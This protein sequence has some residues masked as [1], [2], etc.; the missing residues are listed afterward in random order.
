VTETLHTRS[1][2]AALGGLV[3]QL[4]AGG[5][6]LALGPLTHSIAVMHLAWYLLG[7]VP[8]WFVALLVFRQ[9]ELA[10]LEALDLEELRREKQATGGGEAL[11]EAEGAGGGFR[12]AEARLRWMQRWLIP[13]FGLLTALYLA[14]MGGYL[15][16]YLARTDLEI[17]G[18]NWPAPVNIA[19]GMVLLAI[20][21]LVTFVYSRYTSGMGRV[22]EWQLLRGCGAYMLGNA[23][24][25]MA[26]LVCLGVYQYAGVASW[27]HVVAYAIP[28]LM[29][30]L[31]IEAAAN[32]VLDIYRPRLAG[33]E[34]RACFD[35][36]L[37][38]LFAEPG[39]IAHSIAEA[40]NYQ[41]GFKVSQT[42]F[43][44]LL[45]RAAAPLLATGAVALWLLTCVVV[46]QPYEHVVIERFGRQLNA[47]EPLGPGLHLKWPWPLEKARAYSTG[48]LHQLSVG[49]KVFDAVPDQ[50]K[51]VGSVQLWTDEQHMGHEHFDFLVCPTRVAGEAATPEE[52]PEDPAEATPD[53]PVHLMRLEVVVQYRI[54]PAQLTRYSQT[55]VDPGA[56]LRA[57][58]WE[59]AS[60]FMASTTAERLLGA[61]LAQVG[62][63]LKARLAQRVADLGLEVVYVG[64]TNVH[65]EKSVAEAY[66]NVVKAEQERVA[67]IRGALVAEDEA[68][69]KAAGDVRTA[70]ALVAAVER[71]RKAGEALGETAAALAG[72]PAAD[73][74]AW[75]E[76][77]PDVEQRLRAK[78]E[79]DAQL[80][81]ARDRLFEIEQALD[82]GFGQTLEARRRAADAVRKAE[83]DAERVAAEAT[84]AL[85]PLRARA[86]QRL[87]P[88]QVDALGQSLEAR[89]ARAYLEEQLNAAFTPARLEG[90]AAARLAAALGE[91]WTLE[92]DAARELTQARNEREAYHAAPEV[93]KARR[94]AEV[95]ADGLKD[96]R[97]FL[98][99]FAPGGRPVRVRFMHED[100]AARLDLTQI[101]PGAPQ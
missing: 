23:L 55:L 82:L 28:I 33:V 7:G 42:W 45:E 5:A 58:A 1:R 2:R 99:G 67:S 91:R 63:T 56:A 83:T 36:R 29:V 4:A 37:L 16:R 61:E 87:A 13:A 15:W 30:V 17:S 12:V 8:I 88:P 96:A 77:S 95:L 85:A 59:E 9:H 66:R 26:L 84:Q 31:A 57:L 69:S 35:S 39:G 94:L 46:V 54:Q 97:K 38:G 25:F 18:T 50:S 80:E 65:P 101:S 86:A 81:R 62:A 14:A 72:I 68:L 92:M 79:A 44:Q 6:A 34:P 51:A 73:L 48:R 40:I 75:S 78:V 49:F 90:E 93:Y 21:M 22:A 64:V 53:A 3:L 100:E 98:L 76:L 32:F 20:G 60:R 11:F 74:A 19:I 70:R 47:A 41:F 52:P 27:E 10:A 89:T 43:Y 71:A 24:V